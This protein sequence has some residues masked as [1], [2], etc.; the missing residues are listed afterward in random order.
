[1]AQRLKSATMVKIKLPATR[2]RELVA[3]RVD[4]FMTDYPYS[5]RLLDNADWARLIEPPEPFFVLPYGYAVKQG[6]S[7]W[8]ATVDAFVSRIKADGRLQRAA[9]HHGLNTIVV[10]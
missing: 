1:M 4:V 5:R 6:D 7:A 10:R 3:G 8:L 9:G 2:E